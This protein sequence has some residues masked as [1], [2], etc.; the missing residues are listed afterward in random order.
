MNQELYVRVSKRMLVVSENLAYST[1]A[2]RVSRGSIL[3]K[4]PNEFFGQ[5]NRISNLN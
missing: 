5:L 1:Q 3:W 2:S 4:I